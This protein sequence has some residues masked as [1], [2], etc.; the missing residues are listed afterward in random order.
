MQCV[1]ADQA[2]PIGRCCELACRRL[3]RS[4]QWV[5]VKQERPFRFPAAYLHRETM[6]LHC[7]VQRLNPLDRYPRR[8]LARQIVKLC[9]IFI[10]YRRRAVLLTASPRVIH[11]ERLDA[12]HRLS[13]Q[14]VMV[15]MQTVLIPPESPPQTFDE[16]T[17][18]DVQS[19]WQ[20]TRDETEELCAIPVCR[21][22]GVSRWRRTSFAVF[23]IAVIK[24]GRIERGTDCIEYR[25]RQRPC[26]Q[27]DPQAYHPVALVVR[28]GR[29]A[30]V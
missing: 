10:S 11:G 15:K 25:I 1:I 5:P 9:A 22:I 6:N 8:V 26:R 14:V 4:R 12:V 20:T 21:E 28:D 24:A 18:Y 3:Q 23:I 29:R 7:N 2:R 27:I 30:E 13:M 19:G 16:R 17:Q